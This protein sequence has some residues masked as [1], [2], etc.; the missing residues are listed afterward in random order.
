MSPSCFLLS[1]LL[2]F[3]HHCII[4]GYILFCNY[5]YHINFISFMCLNELLAFCHS[6]IIASPFLSS[7]FWSILSCLDFTIFEFFKKAFWCPV[8]Y[9]W[10]VYESCP[11][12]SALDVREILACYILRYYSVKFW[13]HPLSCLRLVLSSLFIVFCNVILTFGLFL[14]Y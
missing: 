3:Y 1:A 4:Q 14:M 12:D 10:P 2:I 8:F 13:E 9:V 7:L 6:Y 11:E 5:S